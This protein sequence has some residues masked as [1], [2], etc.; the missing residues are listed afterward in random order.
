MKLKNS[1]HSQKWPD[2]NPKLISKETIQLVIQINGKVRD[3]ITVK[4]DISEKEAQELAKSQEKM[5]KWL[6]GK[7]IR[8]IIFIPKKLINIVI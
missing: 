3:K 4:T 8:K 1:I 7:E 5:Q 2:Y 6:E